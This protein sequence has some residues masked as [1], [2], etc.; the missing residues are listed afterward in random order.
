MA[1][2]KP[3]YVKRPR[4]TGCVGRGQETI[5]IVL[6]GDMPLT[7]CFEAERSRLA[8][9]PASKIK[10]PCTRQGAPNITSLNRVGCVSE[11]FVSGSDA[12]RD[13]GVEVG[14][15][16]TAEDSRVVG[17]TDAVGVERAV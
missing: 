16:D 12:G 7:G 14:D 6:A 8:W 15:G 2:P 11:G 10:G 5:H 13:D 1:S 3:V 4:P 9:P 17:E